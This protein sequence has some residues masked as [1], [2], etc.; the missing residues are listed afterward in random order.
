M[1]SPCAC[2]SAMR[3]IGA[4]MAR[5]AA[6]IAFVLRGIAVSMTVRPSSSWTRKTL[7]I[8]RR[9]TRVTGIAAA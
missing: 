5:A 9:L 1:W 4:P 8:P 7:T 6:M 2:V 3:R